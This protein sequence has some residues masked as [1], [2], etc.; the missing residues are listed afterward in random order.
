MHIVMVMIIIDGIDVGPVITILSYGHAYALSN[1]KGILIHNMF[2]LDCVFV[3]QFVFAVYM[4]IH[5]ITNIMSNR[6]CY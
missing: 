2:V 4:Y 5:S 1:V 3:I 6:F